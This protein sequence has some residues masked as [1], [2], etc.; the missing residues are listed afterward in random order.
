MD[1]IIHFSTNIPNEIKSS[2]IS[3]EIIV[4]IIGATVTL[5][6]LIWSKYLEAKISITKELREKKKPT[7]EKV[8]RYILKIKEQTNQ[9]KSKQQNKEEEEE[10]NQ[11]KELLDIAGDLIIWASDD[12]LK[13]WI[14]IVKVAVGN[15][16]KELKGPGSDSSHDGTISKIDIVLREIRKDLG[17]KNKNIKEDEIMSMLFRDIK[18]K[19]T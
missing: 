15:Y 4:G 10:A 9:P 1:T 7:Y 19:N 13:K 2:F 8:I 14:E 17:H 18:A 12:V 5:V 11:R 3:N 6:S 16:E